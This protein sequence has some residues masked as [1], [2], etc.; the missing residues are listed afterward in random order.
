[1]KNR[2][3]AFAFGIALL[4]GCAAA[5]EPV[6]APEPVQAPEPLPPEEPIIA[7]KVESRPM[8]T[9]P[10][11]KAEVQKLVR[12]S[13]ELLNEGEEEK[14][15]TELQYAQ[16][17]DPDN[18][19]VACLL[20]GI[21]ADPVTTLG[22]ESTS[23][24]VRPGESLGRI[25]QRALG[26]VCEFY[27]LARYNHIKVPKQLPAGQVIRIPGK[28]ALAPPEA[29]PPVQP[30]PAPEPPAAK[31]AAKDDAA[32][33]ALI[34]RHHRNAQAAFRRQDLTTAI[35]EWDKVLELDPSNELARVRRE[36]ALDLARRLKQIK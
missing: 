14:A 19:A 28:V 36:E 29:V 25:A 13:F 31:P 3:L 6:K 23:Y 7:P 21:N 24:T 5:P 27:I 22:K 8:L 33:R 12:Q 11:A 32:K 16:Q 9:G 17:L 26:D 2:H 34:Q 1:M 4:A 30:P 18:K 20:R 10:A 15:K 35:K